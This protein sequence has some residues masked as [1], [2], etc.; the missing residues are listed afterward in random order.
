MKKHLNVLL[1][2]LCICQSMRL[3]AEQVP[4]AVQSRAMKRKALVQQ[5]IKELKSSLQD[6]GAKIV[7]NIE[8]GKEKVM[9]LVTK[10]KA[11]GEFT[12]EDF[13]FEEFKNIDI[14]KCK[15]LDVKEIKTNFEKPVW[16]VKTEGST[17]SVCIK[18]RNE[19]TRSFRN[20]PCLL[21]I[22][23]DCIKDNVGTHGAGGFRKVLKDY[24]IDL[25][26]NV[27]PDNVTVSFSC[28]AKYYDL[29]LSF[30]C[31]LMTQS[32]LP[33]NNIEKA[34]NLKNLIRLYFK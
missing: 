33:E 10:N 1:T 22:L 30:V 12:P 31:E 23:K 25:D 13:K 5:G 9:N 34:S 11:T 4:E 7:K 2:A 20:K 19:G 28:L 24:A 18:F 8:K 6:A 16:F 15:R 27:D 29:A 14:S 26:F 32:L 21:Q 17:V 3:C